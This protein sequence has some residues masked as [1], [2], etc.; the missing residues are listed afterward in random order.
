[1]V[2]GDYNNSYLYDAMETSW[3]RVV[4]NT[5]E[6]K[7][8]AMW[9][10]ICETIASLSLFGTIVSTLDVTAT[11]AHSVRLFW[12][13]LGTSNAFLSNVMLFVD[14]VRLES[15]HQPEISVS[16]SHY[17]QVRLTEIGTKTRSEKK[18]LCFRRRI[19]IRRKRI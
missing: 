19:G 15:K 14:K 11:D 5:L 12:N 7:N 9:N 10:C 1:M 6:N 13:G 4:M 2:L 18:C 8:A 17:E 3:A 16:S